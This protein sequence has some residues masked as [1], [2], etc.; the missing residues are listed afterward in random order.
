MK[1]LLILLVVMQ[2]ACMTNIPTDFPTDAERMNGYSNG[3]A[4]GER[5]VT[6]KAVPTVGAAG[7]VGIICGMWN[8]RGGADDAGGVLWV[9]SDGEKVK[10]IERRDGWVRIGRGEWVNGGA[11]C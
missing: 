9:L 2:L 1:R 3:Y 6:D 11:L 8:V 7:E 10:I 4:A 5:M